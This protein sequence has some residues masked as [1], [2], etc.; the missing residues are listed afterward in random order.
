MI[1]INRQDYIDAKNRTNSNSG[2]SAGNKFNPN[3]SEI[4]PQFLR[5][6]HFQL[7]DKSQMPPDQWATTY[8]QTMQPNPIKID[9]RKSNNSFKSSICINPDGDQTNFQ[10]ESRIKYLIF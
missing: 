7:G 8:G 5:T 6:S 2:R 3:F 4:D 1:S 9:D 10:T